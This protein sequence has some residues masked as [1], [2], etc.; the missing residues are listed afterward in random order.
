MIAGM[1]TKWSMRLDE[2][3]WLRGDRVWVIAA[4]VGLLPLIAAIYA[5]N[6]HG[7]FQ[8]DDR[9]TIVENQL[10]QST[11]VGETITPAWWG[12][13]APVIGGGHYRPFTFA[14]YAVNFAIGGLD[15]FGYHVVNVVLHW[16]ATAALMALMWIVLPHPVPVIVAGAVFAVNPANSEAVNYIAARPSV[17]ASGLYGLAIAGFALFRRFQAEGRVTAGLAAAGL[18][19]LGL[20]LGLSSKEI[21]VT[22]PLLWV[23]YDIGWSRK[24]GWWRIVQPYAVGLILLIGYLLWTGYYAAIWAVLAGQ[25]PPGMRSFG[26]NVWT[27][28]SLLPAYLA[29]FIW[30]FHLSVFHDVAG[31]ASPWHLSVLWGAAAG[32][33][34]AG[35]GFHWL[36]Q[37]EN[38]AATSPGRERRAAGF[39]LLW[40]LVSLLPTILYPLH[41]VFQEHRVYL[42]GMGLAAL[43]GIGAWR[44]LRA[45]EEGSVVR[46]LAPIGAILVLGAIA[47]ATVARNGVWNDEVTLWSD[48]AVKAPNNAIPRINLGVGYARRGDAER[49]IAA[50]REA[51]TRS[52][53][54]PM[55]YSNLGTLYY[56]RGEY[57]PA[58][59]ALEAAVA[60]DSQNMTALVTLGLT[61][62]ALGES[63]R[64]D[65][66]FTRAVRTV[67][68]HPE[69]P[70]AR[71]AVADALAKGPRWRA[72]EAHYR[73]LLAGP[74]PP[75]AMLA[76]RAHLGLGFLAERVGDAGAA[77]V[78]YQ[79]AIRLDPGLMD[80][81]F[82]AAN[83]LL[84]AGRLAE[85][86]AAYEGILKDAPGFFP[87]RFNLGRLYEQAGRAD[88]ARAQYR[89]FLDLAPPSP[90]YAAAR[91]HAA[92]R[93]G[94]RRE[95]ERP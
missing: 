49:A 66:V 4:M 47:A 6:L 56:G 77:L 29:L 45:A 50:Y 24:A 8:Y 85:A 18:A 69:Q 39:F 23:C 25:S 86:T 71:L 57:A 87:V 80:A 16:A 14:T 53:N 54:S 92:A 38:A 70:S 58:R 12:R 37:G 95:G 59:Q 67:E 3:G 55:A 5:N 10:L 51:L 44:G 31:V 93:L 21:A 91:A 61:Y 72:A 82:N 30:P 15:P 32:V 88:D 26:A 27:Q 63:E 89:A 94:E 68:E 9:H 35:L 79:E 64:A 40:F 36:I 65:A 84:R 90:T 74:P 73:G 60:L 33:V 28:V 41:A 17:L 1:P 43:A 13:E 76:A 78:S 19:V 83:L 11:H 7:V 75:H 34:M 62:D 2:A 81:R 46:R 22:I 52:P 20:L 42:P 48:A